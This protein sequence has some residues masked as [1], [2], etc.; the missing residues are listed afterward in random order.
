M[1][2]IA[3]RL[4]VAFPFIL[5]GWKPEKTPSGYLM[6]SPKMAADRRRAENEDWSEGGGSP[7]GSVRMLDL[8]T[9]GGT[10]RSPDP[11]NVM[12]MNIR[13]SH[14]DIV[15]NR[16]VKPMQVSSQV[17]EKASSDGTTNKQCRAAKSAKY[18]DD[19][20]WGA[21]GL[22]WYSETDPLSEAGCSGRGGYDRR[23]CKCAVSVERS[24]L[25]EDDRYEIAH[26]LC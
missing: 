11:Q 4:D 9:Q 17:A 10:T 14:M 23:Y 21:Y 20:Y 12:K 24:R 7:L 5:P 18:E 26:R 1:R 3:Q 8:T 25:Y 16:N 15:E 22:C 6:I 19:R 2:P 13:K